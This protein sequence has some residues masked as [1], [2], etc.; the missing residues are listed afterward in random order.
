MSRTLRC[1]A[2][3]PRLKFP[4]LA[5]NQRSTSKKLATEIPAVIN[6][7]VLLSL[8]PLFEV[9][10]RIVRNSTSRL[11]RRGNHKPGLRS[12]DEAMRRRLKLLPFTVT[13]PA[14]ERDFELTDK[15]RAEW[16]GILEWMIEGCLSWQRKGLNAP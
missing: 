2:N 11:H 5:N 10:S 12:V 15:L 1:Q 16:G 6:S 9:C 13:I 14:A 3:F 7:G 8:R 4:R